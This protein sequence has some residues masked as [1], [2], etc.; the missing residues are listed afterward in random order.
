[1]TLTLKQ[2]KSSDLTY[3]LQRWNI[4]GNNV[5]ATLVL[6]TTSAF[7]IQG[8]T[9]DL[10][11]SDTGGQYFAG[12]VVY[13]QFILQGSSNNGAD[14]NNVSDFTFGVTLPVVATPAPATTA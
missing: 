9:Y 4:N 5:I 2:A 11:L 6:P 13:Q 12:T 3:T 1:M 14:V 8:Q 7:P 10:T